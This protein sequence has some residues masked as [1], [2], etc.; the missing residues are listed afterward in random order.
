MRKIR[1]HK[2]TFAKICY[3][4]SKLPVKNKAKR[5]KCQKTFGQ[6]HFVRKNCT[7]ANTF[8]R[9]IAT[10]KFP[11]TGTGKLRTREKTVKHCQ[12]QEKKDIKEK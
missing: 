6:K 11:F 4:S 2:I 1:N 3:E 9:F 8:E 12:E 7:S 5:K 10:H